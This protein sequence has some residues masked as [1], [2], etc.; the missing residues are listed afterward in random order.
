MKHEPFEDMSQAEMQAWLDETITALSEKKKR[1][2]CIL[3]ER[4]AQR[5]GFGKTFQAMQREQD[6]LGDTIEFLKGVKV[7]EESEE[8]KSAAI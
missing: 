4:R 8:F 2:A 7:I 5:Q 6:L 1:E 3:G